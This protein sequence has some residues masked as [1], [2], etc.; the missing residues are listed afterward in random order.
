[1][2]PLIE[3]GPIPVLKLRVDPELRMYPYSVIH[4]HT[5]LSIRPPAS[6]VQKQ[7]SIRGSVRER[8]FHRH[9]ISRRQREQIIVAVGVCGGP[10]ACVW[11]FLKR[12]KHMPR[13]GKDEREAL[14]TYYHIC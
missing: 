2:S 10:L 4:S 8:H 7:I 5:R 12:S 3:L 11:R 1:M 9:Q 6:G 14:D 13:M